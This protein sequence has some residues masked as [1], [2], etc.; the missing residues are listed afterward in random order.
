MK[1]KHTL[2]DQDEQ[3]GS[4]LRPLAADVHTDR[5]GNRFDAAGCLGK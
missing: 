2:S 4:Y 1:R 3:R 5:H